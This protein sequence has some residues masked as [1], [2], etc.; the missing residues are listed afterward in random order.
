MTGQGEDIVM[1]TLDK[2]VRR[3][4]RRMMLVA[5]LAR[6]AW[7]WCATLAVA[8]V[9]IAVGKLFLPVAEPAWSVAWI[10]AALV[11]GLVAASA[12]S[13]AR[14][15]DA[16]EAAVEIDRRFGLKER[17]SSSVALAG[18]Q[19]DT[20]IGRALVEDAEKQ[21]GRI[22]VAGQF[23]VRPG[24]RA[25][26]PLV[27]AALALAIAAFVPLRTP[28][29]P[30]KTTKQASAAARKSTRALA[31]KLD[32]RRKQAAE[33]GLREIDP[34]LAKLEQGAKDLAESS[35]NDRKETLVA[36]N[37]LVRDA[38]KRRHE[39]G[40][41]GDLKKQ[42]A[43]LKDLDTGPADKL[44]KALKQGDFNEALKELE[45][46]K[47]D[48]AKL[49]PDAQKALAEQLDQLQ[50]ALE[51]KVRAHEQ[52]AQQLKDQIE[53]ERRA[54]NLARA[55][56][57]QQQ[58]EKLAAQK[59][60]MGKLGQMQQ[61]LKEAARCMGQGDCDKAAQA[62]AQLGDQ[63]GGMQEEL[64]EME[65]LDGVL[66]QVA[67]CKKAM[68]CKQ[69]DGLGC[70]ECQG[71]DWVKHDGQLDRIARRG[72]GKGIGVGLGPGLGPDTN[73][74]GKFYDSAVKQQAGRG[75]ARVVG[76]A[77]GPNRKG[78]VLEDIQTEFSS[79]DQNTADVV[80]EQRLPRDYRDHAQRYF[81]ALREGGA[82]APAA[83]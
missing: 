46:L 78:R 71:G 61:Q 21:V 74:D 3:A 69:C 59:P 42:L 52:M 35:A 14:R 22:D 27:P 19:R 41:S 32:A 50:Q 9:A 72:G 49:D 82:A 13:W 80:S 6:L 33:K 29:A 26:L 23:R 16:L 57:L 73:P 68:A 40:G 24:R 76:E 47:Q 34:L 7:C 64:E 77:H 58:L 8:A 83:K 11:G 79:A 30:A 2:Q 15:P 17:V 56:Q 18:G 10:V 37:N 60:Q 12:W 5:L 66:E 75:P 38:E 55:D 65:M 20:E 63:L 28:E 25:L 70:A 1:D 43:N 81:D 31:K 48:L 44:G 53:A 36:L 62:L 51:E 45:K 67:D 39:L 4:G 54:G